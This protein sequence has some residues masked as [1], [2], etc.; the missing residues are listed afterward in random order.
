MKKWILILFCLFNGL[1]L[2]SQNN[3][4]GY[5]SKG[6]S[7]SF[8]IPVYEL[9]EGKF[10]KPLML[11][12][13]YRFPLFKDWRYFNFQMHIR[14][15]YNI[16]FVTEKY[17]HEFGV[18]VCLEAVFLLFENTSFGVYTGSG[19]HYI[20]YESKRQVNGFIFSDNFI[21]SIRFKSRLI[22]NFETEIYGGL[23][24]VSNAGIKNPNW[25]INNWI[26]G[27]SAGKLF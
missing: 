13:Y 24:H 27:I 23:R 15:Q 11:Q 1:S 17:H 12:Y 26:V 16:V 25:G 4:L 7:I 6:G 21:A 14:P 3:Y 9:P 8:G 5:K 19:P 20:S 10:Y 2:F 22:E 18:N